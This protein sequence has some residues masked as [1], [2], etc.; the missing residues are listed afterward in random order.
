M[1]RERRSEEGTRNSDAVDEN[2]DQDK[3][4]CDCVALADDSGVLEA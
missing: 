1:H 2:F 4:M 3:N